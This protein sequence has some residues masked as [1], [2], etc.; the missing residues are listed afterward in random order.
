MMIT[1]PAVWPEQLH[2]AILLHPGEY[3]TVYEQKWYE[4]KIRVT[5]YCR[6]PL[7]NMVGSTGLEP[8]A[9]AL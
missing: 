8:V 7:K 2:P 9:P 3:L 1:I 5:A 4:Q 6:N